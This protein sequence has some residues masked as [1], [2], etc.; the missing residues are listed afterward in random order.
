M[1]AANSANPSTRNLRWLCNGGLVRA[2]LAHGKYAVESMNDIGMHMHELRMWLGEHVEVF[3]VYGISLALFC[4][5][6]R[7]YVD[8]WMPRKPMCWIEEKFV[9]SFEL[10]LSMSRPQGV[11]NTIAEY[12]M[13]LIRP[14]SAF[15]EC[16]L[17]AAE[18]E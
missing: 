4:A 1:L 12:D 18:L 13:M 5:L 15:A 16:A 3:S 2:P 9:M 11:A 6:W 14:N 8:M 10:I 7:A 17:Q